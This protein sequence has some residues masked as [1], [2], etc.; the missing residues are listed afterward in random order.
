[1]IDGGFARHFVRKAAVDSIIACRSHVKPITQHQRLLYEY[2]KSKGPG[3]LQPSHYLLS[4]SQGQNHRISNCELNFLVAL[5]LPQ[6]SHEIQARII[7]VF[8]LEHCEGDLGAWWR[9]PIRSMVGYRACRS[10]HNPSFQPSRW[11]NMFFQPSQQ[12]FRCKHLIRPRMGPWRWL[13]L[14]REEAALGK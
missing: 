9:G 14:P 7:D 10:L 3:H 12:S 5:F 1:V 2:A 6:D 11:I 13:Q 4:H 8:V